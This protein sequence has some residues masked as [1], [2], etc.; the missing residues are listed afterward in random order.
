M[1]EREFEQLVEEGIAAI[2]EKFL[3]MLKNVAVVIAEEPT[4]KQRKTAGLHADE[5]LLG[6]YEGIPQVRRDG[7]YFGVL[8]DKITIFKKPILEAAEMPE[9]IREI[10][11]ET[12]WHEIAH[13]FGMEEDEVSRAEERRLRRGML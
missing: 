8:P 2:P 4:P 12:V 5:T 7:G 6:L 1:T 3:R 11:K 9:E 10:V 13:H